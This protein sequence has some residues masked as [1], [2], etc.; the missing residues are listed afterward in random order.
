MKSQ[1]II[2]YGEPLKAFE[3]P[4]PHQ[5]GT[6]VLVS[7]S[8]CGVCHSDLHIHDGYFSLGNNR[9]LD[10]SGGRDLP[11]TL[12]H[13]IHGKVAALGSKATGIDEMDECVV[14]PWIG[15]GTC[16]QCEN[17]QEN[18]CGSN[19]NLGTRKD[20]GFSDHV[21]VPH[22]RY[23]LNA[24]GIPY[25][26][27]GTYMCSGLTAYSALKKVGEVSEKDKIL[28]LG[29]GGV[30]YMGLQLARA[31]FGETILCADIDASKRDA[32]L[33]AGAKEVYDPSEQAASK[34]V[35]RDTSGGV[36]AVLDFVGSEAS[37]GFGRKCLRRGGKLI[38]VGL[39]GGGIEID[40]PLMALQGHSIIG[41]IT[42]SLSEARELLAL[43][44]KG[45]VAEIPI[46]ERPLDQANTALNDLRD[47]KV[48]GR[49]VLTP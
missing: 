38:L 13:E 5:T 23:L 20:G 25:G 15:C 17:G 37:V 14:Y 35:I 19:R 31:L 49:I 30:G 9:K 34:S 16:A 8:H 26:L 3:E 29:I 36:F 45:K 39:F 22:P 43:V 48:I 18:L 28:I 4:N 42:G 7:V 2:G 44:K 32:A 47:G 12:G 27:A 6:E 1:K 40:L 11:F 10:V 46:E 33:K 21:L 41:S 24:T